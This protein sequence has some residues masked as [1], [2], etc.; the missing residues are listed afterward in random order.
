[1]SC[2]CKQED[3]IHNLQN[4]TMFK[5]FLIIPQIWLDLPYKTPAKQEPNQAKPFL[6]KY[7]HVGAI[8]ITASYADRHNIPP[9][10]LCYARTV[11][12]L[13]SA[14][15]AVMVDIPVCSLICKE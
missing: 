12:A 9:Q 1:M 15:S 6:I 3:S 5:W 13:R 11:S 7:L 4:L 2:G 10:F 8:L 14:A